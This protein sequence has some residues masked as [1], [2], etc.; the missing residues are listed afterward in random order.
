MGGEIW[1]LAGQCRKRVTSLNGC[2]IGQ[3]VLLSGATDELLYVT[4]N[5]TH[6][7]HHAPLFAAL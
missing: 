6:G 5:L 3:V 1:I 2:R 7:A 4:V